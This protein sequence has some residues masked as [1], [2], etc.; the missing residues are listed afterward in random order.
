[1]RRVFMPKIVDFFLQVLFFP[2]SKIWEFAYWL[3]RE[4]FEYGLLKKNIFQ[5]P[6]ISV[7]NVTFG[8]TGKTPFIIYLSKFL[9]ENNKVPAILTR[10]YKGSLENSD[11]IIKGESKFRPNPVEFGDEPLLISRRLKKGAVIV[12][13]NRSANLK[14]YFHEVKPDVV[15]LDDGFQHL[16]IFRS[17]NIVLFDAKMPLE[18]YKV[19][20]RGYLREG[21]SALKD[22]D[23]II[24]SRC[25]MV[26]DEVIENLI[27]FLKPFHHPKITIA[28]VR[29]IATGL[30]DIYFNKIYSLEKLKDV[31]VIGVVGIASPESFFDLLEAN[32]A[33][34]VEKISFP[35]HHYFTREDI[36]EIL[37][38]AAKHSAIVVTSEKDI[39]KIRKVSQDAKITYVNIEVDFLSGEGDFLAQVTKRLSLK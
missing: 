11:G 33:E 6:V 14:K 27:N 10:G 5:V 37:E 3:R 17:C 29:Y 34:V 31:K 13:K 25:D 2:L 39:V 1:M 30:Y 23:S 4:L 18:R 16:K 35:D 15:L 28:R 24:I 12:G 26:S 32:G 19:A 8:G 22:A 21:L 7:G 20:P 9:E 36:N 38:S